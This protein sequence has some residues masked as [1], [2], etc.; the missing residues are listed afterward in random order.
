MGCQGSQVQILLCRPAFP[1]P[2]QLIKSLFAYLHL[3]LV[4]NKCK[5]PAK[6]TAKYAAIF[7]WLTHQKNN[8]VTG[9]E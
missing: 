2:V 4:Q 6:K 9:S 7:V 8:Q 3:S 1:Y 5:R